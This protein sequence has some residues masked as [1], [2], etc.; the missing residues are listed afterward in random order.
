MYAIAAIV[1]TRDIAAG[2]DVFREGEPG[3][4]LYIGLS[5]PAPR[6]AVV[7]TISA[8]IDGIG[9]DPLRPPLVW[10]A[11]DG[12]DWVACEVDRDTTGGIGL[13]RARRGFLGV[14][15]RDVFE[16]RRGLAHG[17]GHRQ[18]FAAAETAGLGFLRHA[19]ECRRHGPAILSEELHLDS[20][21]IVTRSA[22]RVSLFRS[23]FRD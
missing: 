14:R 17:A 23:P 11:F 20:P 12:T 6:N 5:D 21:P 10:E 18:E 13:H 22:E 9:V 3:D 2:K 15:L 16:R 19:V 4:A 7:L 1:D 8:S